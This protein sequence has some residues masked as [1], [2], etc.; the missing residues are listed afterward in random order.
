M[1]QK[2]RRAVLFDLDGVLVD[3]ERYWYRLFNQ[4]LVHFGHPPIA[5]RQF[6]QHW[7]QST[8]EDVRIFMPERTLV[9]VRRYFLR[10]RFDFQDHFRRVVAADVVLAEIKKQG[11]KIGCVTNSHRPIVDLEL[12]V[13]GLRRFLGVIITA[14]DVGQPKP[15]PD[16]L[17]EAC[18]RL[19]V[20]PGA[21]VF[22]GDTRTD[23]TAARRAGCRFIGFRLGKQPAVKELKRIPGLLRLIEAG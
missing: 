10:R 11:W 18:C 20:E 22:I 4:A 12:S 17:L 8:A 6:R 1:N 5:Y 15:A 13:T 9:E 3:S 19:R 2:P 23:Q 21:A 7:G 14:D 16:M